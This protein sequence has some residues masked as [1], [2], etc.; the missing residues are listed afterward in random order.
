MT[1]IGP[2]LPWLVTTMTV[3][4]NLGSFICLLA[5]SKMLEADGF[6]GNCP[7]GSAWSKAGRLPTTTVQRNSRMRNLLIIVCFRPGREKNESSVL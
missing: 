2:V 6:G 1:P 7:E 5:T 4:R 3:L